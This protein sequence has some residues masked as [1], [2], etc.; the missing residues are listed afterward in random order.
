MTQAT[1]LIIANKIYT[2]NSIR[3]EGLG[4]SIIN[5]MYNNLYK[6]MKMM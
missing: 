5:R 6:I 2:L 3:K 4:T 1:N